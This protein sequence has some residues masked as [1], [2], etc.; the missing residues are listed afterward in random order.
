MCKRMWERWIF[1]GRNPI[2]ITLRPLQHTAQGSIV[3]LQRLQI[4][5]CGRDNFALRG[6]VGLGL[7]EVTV[8]LLQVPLGVGDPIFRTNLADG[9]VIV[10]TEQQDGC[11]HARRYQRVGKQ[12][13]RGKPS[14]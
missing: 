10:L 8:H 12:Y 9:D 13:Q 4:A 14:Q 5:A 1:T 3:R 2:K 7:L 6:C 11:W